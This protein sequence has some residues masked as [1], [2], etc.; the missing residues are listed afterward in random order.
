M[1]LRE[2]VRRADA[3]AVLRATLPAA[4][5]GLVAQEVVER[6]LGTPGRT[7]GALA[8]AGA[9]LCLADRR[10]SVRAVT[11]ADTAVAGLAQVAALIPGVSRA[12]ATL[13]ALRARGADRD[14]ALRHSLVLSLPITAGAAGLTA[15]RSQQAPPLV[16]VALAAA[17]S[18]ATTRAVLPVSSRLLPVSGVYRLVLAAVVAVRLRREHR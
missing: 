1:A 14:D 13:T 2:D 17:A 11:P 6:R 4:A 9:L 5:V 7:A 3:A 16:P 18:W 15:W 8:A 12:G 10:P